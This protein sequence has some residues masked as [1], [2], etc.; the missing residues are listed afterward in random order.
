MTNSTSDRIELDEIY[1]EVGTELD[2]YYYIGDSI[3]IEEPWIDEGFGLTLDDYG[4]PTRLAVEV[5]GTVSK[6]GTFHLYWNGEP[7][8]TLHFV[9]SSITPLEFTSDPSDGTLTFGHFATIYQ[10]GGYYGIPLVDYGTEAHLILGEEPSSV[11][12]SCIQNFSVL[13]HTHNP[14]RGMNLTLV[15]S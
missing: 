2:L 14:D 5:N 3:S 7:V 6:S 4:F 15:V 11:A 8:W 1:I 13:G 12:Y 10:D 9:D